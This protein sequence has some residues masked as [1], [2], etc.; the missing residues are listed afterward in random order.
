MDIFD[1]PYVGRVFLYAFFGILDAT[2]Q[3]TS[4]WIMGAMSNDPR[5]LA[6]FTGLCGSPS[7]SHNS[8][9]AH[10]YS[11]DIDKSIQSAGAA[12][13]WRADGVKLPFVILLLTFMLS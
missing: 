10:A 8:N 2:W 3:I 11:Y 1:K 13:V 6:Y 12:G 4:Y 5:K 9:I 7:T